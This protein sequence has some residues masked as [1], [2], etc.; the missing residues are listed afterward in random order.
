[1]DNDIKSSNRILVVDDNPAIHDDFQKILGGSGATVTDISAAEA[2]LFGDDI[3][4]SVEATTYDLT[5][6][7]QGEE[8]LGKVEMAIEEGRPFSLAFVDVR[9]PPGWDGIETISRI[10]K[11]APDLQ[12]V[13]CTAYSDYSWEEM[14][15]KLGKTDRL[16]ILKKPFDTVEVHQIASAM[17]EKWSLHQ[18]QRQSMRTME[19]QMAGNSGE[20]QRSLSLTQATLDATADGILVVDN[21]GKITGFNRKFQAIWNLPPSL[22]ESKHYES[23]LNAVLWQLKDPGE[24]SAKFTELTA[25]LESESFDAVEFVDGRIFERYS[26]PQKVG[27]QNV[28]RVWSFRD[29]TER[30]QMEARFLRTQRMESIGALAGGVAHD[31]NNILS[32]IMVSAPLLRENLGQEEIEKLVHNI[33]VSAERGAAIVKQLLTFG[34]G[35]EGETV[36]ISLRHT[37]MEVARIVEETFPRNIEIQTS[38]AKDLWP[39]TGDPTHMHQVALNL[40]INARDAMPQGGTIKMSATNTELTEDDERLSDSDAKPGQYVAFSVSDTGCGISPSVVDKIFDPFFTTKEFGRGSG[41][42]LSTVLG[43]AKSH[44]GFIHVT[45]DVGKGSQF[46]VFI[47]ATPNV[48]PIQPTEKSAPKKGQGEKILVV[49]DEQNVLEATAKLLERNGYEVITCRDGAE[50]LEKCGDAKDAI[51]LVLTDVM[52]PNMDGAAMMR[53]LT[54]LAPGICVVGTSGLEKDE[55][56]D[57]MKELGLEAFLPKPYAPDKLLGVLREV[58]DKD[59]SKT[60]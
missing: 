18:Q 52:M 5:F 11:V 29:I 41:L 26:Q 58:L 43:I 20:L 57:E 56:F 13:I 33:E 42:G 60:D 12:V 50:A 32:P 36:P 51:R 14:V 44:G 46:E 53:Q 35:M 40:C 2:A 25:D 21:E 39:V 16:L 10:W 28:G 6:A 22:I 23:M 9:M 19:T 47:P 8:G 49:D 30:T 7:S 55:R 34:R 37:V 3:S 15:R 48:E 31:L 1:M 27:E 17:T 24:F 59:T 54:K 4:S 45:S 38:A